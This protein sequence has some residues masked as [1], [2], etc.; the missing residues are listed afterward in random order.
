MPLEKSRASRCNNM[1]G[2]CATGLYT[3]S[4]GM[5]KQPRVCSNPVV[6]SL[7]PWEQN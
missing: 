5:K 6:H 4:V 2:A 1:V 7:H 3:S